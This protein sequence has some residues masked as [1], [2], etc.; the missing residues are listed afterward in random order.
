M[1]PLAMPAEVK[2]T[3]RS[4][5][6]S[7]FIEYSQLVCESLP[8]SQIL[9]VRR[10]E[11]VC[12]VFLLDE[13]EVLSHLRSV[14]SDQDKKGQDWLPHTASNVPGFVLG[15]SCRKKPVTVLYL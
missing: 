6:R 8:L 5:L 2:Q 12:V 7:P 10:Q 14:R 9:A 3:V 11:F 15:L 4:G 13:T 1:I